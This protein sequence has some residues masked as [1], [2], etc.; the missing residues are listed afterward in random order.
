MSYG[1]EASGAMEWRDRSLLAVW[2]YPR[3]RPKPG[4]PA[5]GRV[6]CFA[7][8]G[9]GRIAPLRWAPEEPENLPGGVPRGFE[10]RSRRFRPRGGR[11]PPGALPCRA[12][13]LPFP[14]M[15]VLHAAWITDRLWLWG[16][17]PR[18]DSAGASG[19]PQGVRGSPSRLPFDAGPDR[20]LHALEQAAGGFPADRDRLAP[21]VAW[22]PVR[23]RRPVPS[24]PLVADRPN[25]PAL[26]RLRPWTVTGLP[27]DLEESLTLL[28]TAVDRDTLG[29]GLPV[30]RDLTF[31]SEA[32]TLAARLVTGGHLLP[33]LVEEDGHHLARWDPIF[34]GAD[35]EEVARLSRRMPPVARALVDPANATKTDRQ[36][37]RGPGDA[38]PDH[39]PLELTRRFVAGMSDH[40]VR[41]AQ[42]PDRILPHPV[43]LEWREDGKDG[44]ERKGTVDER[45]LEALRMP[46]PVVEGAAGELRDLR[47]RLEEWRRPLTR[48]LNAP[49]RLCFRLEEPEGGADPFLGEG[50]SWQLTYLL[51]DVHEPSLTLPLARA[52]ALDDPEAKVFFRESVHAREH[53]L[54]ALGQAARLSPRVKASLDAPEPGDVELDSVEA[55]HFLREEAPLL[56]EAGFG[57]QLPSWWTRNRSRLRPSVRARA[58]AVG[59][60]GRSGLALAGLAKVSWEVILGGEA[61]SR[62]E[63]EALI[64][65][66]TPLVRLRGRWVEVDGDELRRAMVELARAEDEAVSGSRLVRLALG[67]EDGPAGL[68]V[69]G[70]HAEGELGELLECLQGEGEFRTLPPPADLRAELRPYQERGYSWLAFLARWGL[71]ACLA[72]DMGLGKTIQTLA[73]LQRDREELRGNGGGSAEPRPVLVVAPTSVVTNW[74]REAERFTPSVKVHIHHGPDRPSGEALEAAASASDLVLTTYGLLHRDADEL[75]RVRWRGLVLDEAQQI[76]NPDTRR[77]RAARSMEADFRVALTGTPVENHVGDLWSIM[78]VLNPGLLGSRASFRKRFFL[79]IQTARDP[80]AASRLRRVTGP[81]I[82][83]RLKTDR[84]I[85]RDLP[86]RIETRTYCPLTREQAS[87]YA[88]VLRE[89]EEGLA[90]GTGGI[91]RKG[92]VLATLTRLKQVCNHPAHF[93][94]DGSPIPGRSGKVDRLVELLGEVREA[95]GRTL[96]FTQYTRMGELLQTHLQELFGRELP[97]LHGGVSRKRREE[98]VDRFQEPDGPEIFLLSLKAGG[99]GLNLT[100]ANHVFLFDRWWNPAVER[101]AA[102]RAFRIGQT[103]NVQVHKFLCTGTLEEQIDGILEGKQ[104]VAEQVVGTGEGWL[105]ELSNAALREVLALRPEAVLEEDT[106][107]GEGASS[108]EGGSSGD[109][110]PTLQQ[111]GG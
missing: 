90:E 42:W 47:R 22:L 78:E 57:V 74:S 61:L 81:F 50:E 108:G 45:W 107:S 62:T 29:P 20:L 106:S 99:T 69:E 53:L 89:L 73:L 25:G 109:H 110:R 93:L 71:G 85:I 66:K 68:A 80:E 79:P 104:E 33:G 3:R 94:D 18:E 54:Q 7:D 40:L 12:R 19:V 88:A 60:Q 97:F 64:R 4:A 72:D 46:V 21:L 76:K 87:L 8:I 58:G 1:A 83:R 82:L 55:H 17:A 100:A 95:G 26:P 101:Q 103:R 43:E 111:V 52:W 11:P 65:L 51:Q 28:G 44:D 36:S 49:W 27:L 96:L 37:G 59:F 31:W 6:T 86:E 84:S 5:V 63:I 38:S 9:S 13:P 14:N 102:D 30:S 56:R 23:G 39:S 34:Q 35:L 2:P 41:S 70:V 32:L 48:I 75:A 77:A 10:A 67:A 15:I 91:Q 98:M 16:E 105:T 24:S 92:L